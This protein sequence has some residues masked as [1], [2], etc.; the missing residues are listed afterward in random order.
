MQGDLIS[1]IIPIY[2]VQKY[3]NKCVKS[4]LEQTYGNLEIILVD[5]GSTDSSG[6]I[7]DKC[8]ESDERIVVIHKKNGGLSDARNAGIDISKGEYLFFLDADDYLSPN[9]IEIMY[10]KI[11]SENADLAICNFTWTNS[12]GE[13]FCGE[14][15]ICDE[16]LNKEDLLGKL[17][18]SD[19]FYYVV[20]WN[21][22]YARKLF[23]KLRFTYG[24]I[25]EDEFI[26]HRIFGECNKAVSLSEILYYYIKTN[27]SITTSNTS[28]KRLDYI[29]ALDDRIKYYKENGYIDYA[30]ETLKLLW[31]VYSELYTAV[32][33]T[34]ENKDRMNFLKSFYNKYFMGLISLYNRNLKTIVELIVFR[35]NSQWYKRL[36][37]G[38]K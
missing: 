20:A 2:N 3:L 9:A 8:K 4:V 31:W 38:K 22:L 34:K 21:K 35:I 24:K 11:I 28:I 25:H 12:E 17:V 36:K 26:V 13:K 5:D 30:K 15:V 29:E 27:N 37:R 23:E 14:D 18:K 32:E 19:N 6:E 33:I 1:I 10:S 16:I 7:C